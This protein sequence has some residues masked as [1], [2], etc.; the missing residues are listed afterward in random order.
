M[1]IDLI[2]RL[3]HA[4]WDLT[5]LD[6]NH[7]ENGGQIEEVRQRLLDLIYDLESLKNRKANFPAMVEAKISN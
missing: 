2:T 7:L 5:F 6:V 3:K 1:K 4:Y